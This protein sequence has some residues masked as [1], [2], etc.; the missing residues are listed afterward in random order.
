MEDLLKYLADSLFTPLLSLLIAIVGLIISFNKSKGILKIFTFYFFAFVLTQTI[1][2][3]VLVIHQSWSSAHKISKVLDLLFT[4]LEFL[5]F[6]TLFWTIFFGKS[7]KLLILL[8]LGFIIIAAYFSYRDLSLVGSINQTSLEHLYIAQSLFLLVPCIIYYI[9]VFSLKEPLPLLQDEY[10]WV[11]TGLSFFIVCTLPF[12]Y[13][14]KYLR[15]EEWVLY[16]YLYSIVYLFY[17]LLFTM[18][19]R[20][21][22]CK[23]AQVK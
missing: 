5:I 11:I 7:K 22:L 10:F 16:K 2:F 21:I 8:T 17:C 9:N 1:S 23:P 19:I 18:I 20:A 12:S 6:I 14:M 13:L 15:I 4:V 3:S